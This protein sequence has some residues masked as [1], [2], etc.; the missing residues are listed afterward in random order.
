M[1][2]PECNNSGFH[3][4]LYGTSLYS[5]YERKE[6][7]TYEFKGLVIDGSKRVVCTNCGAEYLIGKLREDDEGEEDV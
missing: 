7:R 5:R 3:I 6:N 4:D 1:K 2:C